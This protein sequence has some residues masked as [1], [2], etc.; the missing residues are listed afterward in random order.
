MF[1]RNLLVCTFM[2]LCV[3]LATA[4]DVVNFNMVSSDSESYSLLADVDT[5]ASFSQMFQNTDM[6]D[7]LVQFG[8]T[9]TMD[10]VNDNQDENGRKPDRKTRIYTL[11]SWLRQTT[12]KLWNAMNVN[13]FIRRHGRDNVM[14]NNYE[15]L[16]AQG[17]TD[18]NKCPYLDLKKKQLGREVENVNDAITFI[19]NILKDRKCDYLETARGNAKR[20][21][22]SLNLIIKYIDDHNKQDI[23]GCDCRE[24][25]LEVTNNWVKNLQDKKS[26]LQRAIAREI[27]VDEDIV[28]D[29][30][31]GCCAF[32]LRAKLQGRQV[33]N[34]VDKLLLL[35]WLA[36][37]RKSS[38][39]SLGADV[40]KIIMEVKTEYDNLSRQ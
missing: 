25:A 39:S 38:V 34:E 28:T 31:E 35:K 30:A 5:T 21:V 12:R 17:A 18:D 27:G 24:L 1:T 40:R 36:W 19:D 15:T 8:M 14:S 33:A 2:A 6:I 29:T 23:Q 9:T 4:S 22:E 3:S 37:H 20:V 10:D 16:C 7:D 32:D 13:T 11:G 26:W